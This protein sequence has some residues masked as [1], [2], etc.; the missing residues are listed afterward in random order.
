[1]CSSDLGAGGSDNQHNGSMKYQSVP[2]TGY[3]ETNREVLYIDPIFFPF[4]V[5][6]QVGPRVSLSGSFGEGL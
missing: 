6:N 1:M 2:A 3:T 5:A 4:T